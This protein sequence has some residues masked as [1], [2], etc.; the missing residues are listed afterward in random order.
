MDGYY[1]HTVPYPLKEPMAERDFATFSHFV[2]SEFSI[3][4]N[5]DGRRFCDESVGYYLNA[6]EVAHLP[7]QRALMLFDARGLS[8]TTNN[9]PGGHDRFDLAV[10]I[11]AH[12]ARGQSWADIE[13]LVSPWGYRDVQNAVVTYNRSLELGDV[14]PG[15]PRLRH[16][17]VDAPFYTLEVQPAITVAHGG[18]R[19]TA[20]GQLLSAENTPIDGLLVAGADAGGLYGRCYFGGLVVGAV[21]GIECAKTALGL[22]IASAASSAPAT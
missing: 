8:H 10:R 5:S 17:L 11:G 2:L 3:L 22:N 20:R 16:P 7:T 6:Q 1:G 15:R 9:V 4:T 12:A 21:F 19:T 13:A 14:T 18:L